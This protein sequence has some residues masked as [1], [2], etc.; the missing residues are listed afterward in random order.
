MLRRLQ[1]R[2]VGV[3][4]I[5][6]ASKPA[7]RELVVTAFPA[8]VLVTRTENGIETQIVIEA[9]IARRTGIGNVTG[10]ERNALVVNVNLT[11]NAIETV[12]GLIEITSA[13]DEMKKSETV[14]HLPPRKNK[15]A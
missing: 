3:V 11:E 5:E 4:L 10:I 8:V 9:G 15:R 14:N 1:E 2:N 13:V 7:R 12:T 6:T